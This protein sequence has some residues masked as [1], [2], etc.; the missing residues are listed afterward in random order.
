MSYT[1]RERVYL[2]NIY[3][4]IKTNMVHVLEELYVVY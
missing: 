1:S 4:H 2:S 3:T